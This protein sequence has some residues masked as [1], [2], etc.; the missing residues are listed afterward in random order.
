MLRNTISLLPLVFVLA[1]CYI[2][3][4]D[5]TLSELK[6]D[7][8]W[9]YL[10]S[11]VFRPSEIKM[12]V[13]LAFIGK[14]QSKTH[15]MFL[16]FVPDEKWANQIENK[17]S[18]G[19]NIPLIVEPLRMNGQVQYNVINF[20]IEKEETYHLVIKDC[21]QSFRKDYDNTIGRVFLKLTM[22]DGK[23]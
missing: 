3:E 2:Y 9:L 20:G 13:R 21:I 19:L 17:C 15:K 22:R 23:G 14:G 16:Q 7:N 12:D 18:S 10:D 5:F 1:T 11:F 4:R 8:G 6:I